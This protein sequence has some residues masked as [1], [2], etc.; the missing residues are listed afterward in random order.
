MWF[1][2]CKTCN[3]SGVLQIRAGAAGRY[4]PSMRTVA[5]ARR[6]KRACETPCGAPDQ[7]RLP[8]KRAGHFLVFLAVAVACLLSAVEPIF[9]ATFETFL[10]PAQV[11]DIST[12]YRDRITKIHVRENDH[13]HRGTLLAELGTGVLKARLAEAEQAA[14]EHGDID[15]ARALVSMRKNRVRMLAE[16]KKTGNAR[17]QELSTAQTELSMARAQLQGALEKQRLKESEVEV[18]KAQIQ[19]KQ[20]I[21][22]IDGIVVT[23]YKQEAEL[24]GGSDPQPLLTI[25]QLDPLHAV[26]HLPP[27]A[28]HSLD[29]RKQVPLL[30]AGQPT[31]GTI[32]FIS[33]IIDAQSGTVTV[34][35]I[36]KNTEHSLDSGSRCTLVLNDIAPDTTTGEPTNDRTGTEK[37]AADQGSLQ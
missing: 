26:F 16:L 25:A 11:V 14:R 20:L 34:R 10:E 7:L 27:P 12:P 17:P 35:I 24:I 29:N 3:W 31:T 28:A 8:G 23:L 13:V 9:A 21:S 18:I 37:P 22:P 33:P 15:A 36:L 6:G 19:E 4:S 5:T 2:L 1:H 32:D 30:V